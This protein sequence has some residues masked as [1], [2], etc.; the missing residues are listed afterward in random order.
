MRYIK[1]N[2]MHYLNVKV[3][4]FLVVKNKGFQFLFL[5]VVELIKQIDLVAALSSILQ[6][7]AILLPEHGNP[8]TI[9]ANPCGI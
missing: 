2:H 8:R 1:S 9:T 5:F 7:Y 4:W 6:R 3:K